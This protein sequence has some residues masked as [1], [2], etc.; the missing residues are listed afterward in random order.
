MRMLTCINGET[1]TLKRNLAPFFWGGGDKGQGPMAYG[2]RPLVNSQNLRPEP[3]QPCT[4][5]IPMSAWQTMAE[6]VFARQTLRDRLA[7]SLLAH[8]SPSARGD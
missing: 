2:P 6:Q 4:P 1:C 3:T 5:I 7:D 8:C